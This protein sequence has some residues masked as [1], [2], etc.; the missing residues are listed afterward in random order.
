MP[1][2]HVSIAGTAHVDAPV[3]LSS[4]QLMRRLGPTLDRLGLWPDLLEVLTG[5]RERRIWGRPTAVAHAAALSGERLLATTGV[6][7]SRIGLLVNTSVCRDHLEPSTASIVHRALGLAPTCQNFDLGNACLGFINGMDVAALMIERGDIGYAMV[8]DGEVSDQLIESTTARL[9]RPETT[10]E[11]FR[12]EFASLTLGSGSVAMLLGHRDLLPHGHRYVGSV[13]RAATEFSDLCRGT[14]DRMV[15]DTTAL[16]TE[17]LTLA[18]TTYEAAREGLG[19]SYR[20]PD[21]YMLHQ[22]S[23]AHTSAL[24]DRL[25][26][27]P[28]KAMTTF[29]EF[30]NVGPA[31]V[32]LTL[33]KAEEAGRLRTGTRVGL[34]GIGSGLNCSMAEVI[35]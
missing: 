1:Y 15:T 23:K 22:V 34:M 25:G 29:G 3:R 19:W 31:S 12:E 27:D 13:T 4:A 9:S 14:M 21:E 33:S 18:A 5:I 6:P 2:E 7:R 10:L 28:A 17:G 20:Q 26:I 16:L 24:L 35:W 30:G 11:Q 32:P 8:V